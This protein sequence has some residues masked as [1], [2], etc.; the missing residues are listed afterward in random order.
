MVCR[1]LPRP[2]EKEHEVD[3]RM[4]LEIDSA[5]QIAP[6]CSMMRIRTRPLNL[7]LSVQSQRRDSWERLCKII[8]G[9]ILRL[10]FLGV[11]W[12]NSRYA[13]PSFCS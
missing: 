5:A 11:G 13:G 4:P 10:N 6:D 8:L 3:D 2:G 12:G 9:K 1:I 7:V